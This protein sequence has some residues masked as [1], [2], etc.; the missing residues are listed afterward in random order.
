VEIKMPHEE[1]FKKVLETRNFE[2]KLFW[3]RSNY[4]LILNGGI[5]TA[6][7]TTI[8]ILKPW[9]F[10]PAFGLVVSFLWFALCLGS[11]YWQSYWEQCLQVISEKYYDESGIC[12]NMNFFTFN[13]DEIKEYVRSSMINSKHGR[14]L[15][16]LDRLILLKPSVST[17]M[18]LIALAFVVG[19]I[20]VLFKI[21]LHT[22]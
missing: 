19:W 11:K 18:I 1:V 2:I 16:C 8:A 3:Q 22:A 4:L 21:G 5:A 12:Q 6:Y 15:R 9:W 7:I 14:L 20:F 10:L 13:K 17:I